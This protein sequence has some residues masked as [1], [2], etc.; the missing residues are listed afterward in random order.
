MSATCTSAL[1]VSVLV[2]SRAKFISHQALASGEWFE[3]MDYETK[4]DFIKATTQFV[5]DTF[6]EDNPILYFATYSAGFDV[7]ELMTT[8][9]ISEEVWDI[10]KLEEHDYLVMMAYRE[11]F[12][13]K[14]GDSVSDSLT[15][16]M[17][18]YVGYFSDSED[19]ALD[20]IE[21][22]DD[23]S[24]AGLPHLNLSTLASSLMQDMKTANDYYFS[25]KT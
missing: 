11:C 12:G 16:A 20:F 14:T 17:R 10:F 1:S 21:N 23:I 7:Q 18:C 13:H 25:L 2:T 22:S 8:D 24:E 9:S 4:A 15:K 19:M 3:L 5:I 6:G